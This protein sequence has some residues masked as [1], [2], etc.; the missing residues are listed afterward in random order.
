VVRVMVGQLAA[1]AG[2]TSA[3]VHALRGAGG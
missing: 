3:S 2:G 1:R